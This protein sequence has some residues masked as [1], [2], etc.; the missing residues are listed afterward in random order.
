MALVLFASSC[1]RPSSPK[2]EPTHLQDIEPIRPFVVQLSSDPVSL[3]PFQAEDGG[4]VRI[5]NNVMDGL[6]GYDA[7]GRLVH[8]L[9]E[10]HSVSEDQRV[11]R[12]TLRQGAKW[13]DSRPI[14]NDEVV[15]GLKKAMN[16]QAGSK[17]A[18]L[19]SVIDTV[20]VKDGKIEIRLKYPATQFLD[21]LTLVSAV[22]YRPDFDSNWPLAGPVTG[23]FLLSRYEIG[24]RIVLK[25]NP[26]Y[27]DKRAGVN[28]IDEVHFQIISD[29]T[30]AANLFSSGRIDLLTRIA[31]LDI[32]RLRKSGVVQEFPMAAT[33]YLAFNQRKAPFQTA[34]ARC[35]VAAE[36]DARAVVSALSGSDRAAKSWIPLGLE[37]YFDSDSMPWS[38]SEVHSKV[39]AAGKKTL[40]EFTGKLVLG[41]DTGQKNHWVVERVQS[42]MQSKLGLKVSI[43][44]M[45]WKAYVGR[46]SSE[47]P[48]IF[49]FAWLSPY[50]DPL[51]HLQVFTSQN[52]NNYTAWKSAKYDRLVDEIAR[53]P[54]GRERLSKIIEA[55]KIL[56]HEECVIVPV[57]HYT[58]S[59]AISRRVESLAVNPLSI[60]RYDE[61]KVRR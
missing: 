58:Q 21:A 52:A 38:P 42:L 32:E 5:L 59:Y 60:L 44:V 29:D 37:G 23:P 9:A 2:S 4:A 6:M 13:S 16:A 24:K 25:R 41:T 46:L 18:Q 11:Y 43:E 27:W 15:A 36:V 61:V 8:R 45:D 34:A 50:L 26:N 1:Q 31:P 53:L 10:S 40:S 30:V 20:S 49:R 57:F 47:P 22:P 33:Y 3:N 17:F 55:E 39:V 51:T 56:L 14:T 54:V 19:L 7:S 35:A 48:A 28:A 12:L